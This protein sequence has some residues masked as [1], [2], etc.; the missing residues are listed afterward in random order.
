MTAATGEAG[1]RKSAVAKE[2]SDPGALTAMAFRAACT[3][4]PAA[5]DLAAFACCLERA[6]SAFSVASPSACACMAS[7]KSLLTT[8]CTLS[9][10]PLQCV[11]IKCSYYIFVVQQMHQRV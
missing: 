5:Y 10:T 4:A 2:G 8:L 1:T 6:F 11:I 9:I 3:S 7:L